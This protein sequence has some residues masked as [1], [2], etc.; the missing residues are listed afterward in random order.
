MGINFVA[1]APMPSVS[2]REAEFWG[3]PLREGNQF[4]NQK[5]GP[6]QENQPVTG[7]RSPVFATLKKCFRGDAEAPA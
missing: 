6:G 1:D 5:M 7:F 4:R 3:I 2:V